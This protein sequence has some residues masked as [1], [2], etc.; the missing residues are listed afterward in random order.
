MI[1][2]VAEPRNRVSQQV[3]EADRGS[4]RGTAGRSR[5]TGLD[6]YGAQLLSFNND[7]GDQGFI[8][9]FVSGE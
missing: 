5:A 4:L 3:E 7:R 1:L 2:V 8:A 6:L 9:K